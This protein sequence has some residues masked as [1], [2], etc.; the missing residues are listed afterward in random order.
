MTKI[1]VW[2]EFLIIVLICYE[3][4]SYICF[5]VLL[6]LLLVMED[7]KE[8]WDSC[9]RTL[10]IYSVHCCSRII[11][12]WGLRGQLQW[13][14]VLMGFKSHLTCLKLTAHVFLNLILFSVS[15]DRRGSVPTSTMVIYQLV[16]RS[17][18][19]MMWRCQV[20]VN[21]DRLFLSFHTLIV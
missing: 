9:L 1:D 3:S 12:A 11:L 10:S 8:L 5:T 18:S 13:W 17:V 19:L 20:N 14:Y 2:Q 6:C 21:T 15:T 4:F 16:T 7:F